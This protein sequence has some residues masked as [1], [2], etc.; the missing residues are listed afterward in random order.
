MAEYEI[1]HEFSYD[2]LLPE[3]KARVHIDKSLVD[4]GWTVVDRDEFVPTAI[5]A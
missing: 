3:Q 1:N 4:A 5:N 2:D